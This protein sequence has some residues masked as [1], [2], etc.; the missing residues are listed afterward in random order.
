MKRFKRWLCVKITGF[1]PTEIEAIWESRQY[2]RERQSD[3]ARLRVDALMTLGRI[4][5]YCGDP[6]A[7]RGLRNILAECEKMTARFEP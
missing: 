7:S 6:D 4:Q 1:T 2:W 3:E 5:S